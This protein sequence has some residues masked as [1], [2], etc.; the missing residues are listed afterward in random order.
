MGVHDAYTPSKKSRMGG[1]IAHLSPCKRKYFLINSAHVLEGWF[2]MT[3]DGGT[4]S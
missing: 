1:K 2:E 4:C 3:Q